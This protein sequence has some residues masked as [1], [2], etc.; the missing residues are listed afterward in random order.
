MSSITSLICPKCR[1]SLR[2]RRDP[3]RRPIIVSCQCGVQLLAQPHARRPNRI[4][5]I[6][7]RTEDEIMRAWDRVREADRDHAARSI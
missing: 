7:L 4:T 6:I 5:V 3:R 2:P 1:R